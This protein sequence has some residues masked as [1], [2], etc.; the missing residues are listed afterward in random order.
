[1][2]HLGRIRPVRTLSVLVAVGA[3]VTVLLVAGGSS[4]A[5]TTGGCLLQGTAN[6]TPGLTKTAKPTT[7][8]FTGKFSNCKGTGKVTGGTVTAS[9][10]GTASCTANTTSGT[11]TVSWNNG[12][13]STIGF[14]T[15]GTGTLVQVAGSFTSGTFAGSKAK[16]ELAFYT[17]TPQACNTVTGLPKASFIGPSTVGV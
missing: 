1:M 15:K 10:S 5:A 8:T 9:G 11:A 12:T 16:A 3:L 17:L 14:T 4:S 13:T 2:L 7:Y 6:L